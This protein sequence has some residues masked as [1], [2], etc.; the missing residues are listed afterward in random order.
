MEA[1]PTLVATLACSGVTASNT[2]GKS[3]LKAVGADGED[4][5]SA[6]LNEKSDEQSCE[7][8]SSLLS[9]A[10][11]STTRSS[12]RRKSALK[13]TT[14]SKSKLRS[15]N[16][17]KFDTNTGL[18]NGNDQLSNGADSGSS[19]SAEEVKDENRP[20]IPIRTSARRPATP[21]PVPVKKNNKKLEN[22]TA[23]LENQSE[24]DGDDSRPLNRKLN[25]KSPNKMVNGCAKNRKQ[26]VFCPNDENTLDGFGSTKTEL[27]NGHKQKQLN[28][29]S[30]NNSN[31]VESN[32]PVEFGLKNKRLK[33][34]PELESGKNS[35]SNSNSTVNMEVEVCKKGAPPSPEINVVDCNG[36]ESNG[37]NIEDDSQTGSV[38]GSGQS[39]TVKKKRRKRTSNYGI[40]NQIDG[41]VNSV[42][43]LFVYKWPQPNDEP[44]KTSVQEVDTYI[45]QE[46]ISEYLGVK[47]FKRKYPDLFRR[48]ID[49]K[50]RVYLKENNVVTETQCDLGLTA[51]RLNDCLDIMAD[52]YPEKYTELSEYLAKQR[53]KDA[54]A[55]IAAAAETVVVEQAEPVKTG[56]FG[57]A[58]LSEADRMKELMKKAIKSVTAFNLNLQKEKKAE[59]GSYFDLQTMRIQQRMK[60]PN[61]VNIPSIQVKNQYPVALLT[62]QYQYHYKKYSNDEMKHLPINTVLYPPETPLPLLYDEWKMKQ[63][64]PKKQYKS[65]K[66][67]DSGDETEEKMEV[68]PIE[69]KKMTVNAHLLSQH[70]H[71]QKIQHQNTSSIVNS[72][73]NFRISV[74]AA[75]T[76][77]SLIN[78]QKLA[79]SNPTKTTPVS[80]V[81][82]MKPCYVCS[83]SSQ[84][85][86]PN[87]NLNQ[88]DQFMVHCTSCD[89]YSHPTCL[90][91]NPSLVR[92]QSILEY[93][94]QCMDCKKCSGCLKPYDEDKMMFCDRCDRG[95]HTYCVGLKEVPSGSWFCKQCNTSETLPTNTN[96]NPNAISIAT[97]QT[98]SSS[99]VK[100]QLTTPARILDKIR[101]SNSTPKERSSTG[102]R[103]RPLGSLN[104]PKDPGSPNKKLSKY[105]LKQKQAMESSL[106]YSSYGDL[107]GM[108]DNSNTNPTSIDESYLHDDHSQSLSY[109]NY[110][111]IININMNENFIQSTF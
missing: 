76:V 64:N 10:S 109:D 96:A 40:I 90:E 31:E 80:T 13:V 32:M 72:P 38:S 47:S 97:N 2:Q 33:T 67:D 48:L 41:C 50:E 43:S 39:E 54:A 105:K 44:D 22:V 100:S 35:N 4:E 82:I 55:A 92:W 106:N 74:S 79:T 23:T 26:S 99:M 86:I 83:R 75:P 28:A 65:F 45:L 102:K 16:N 87:A 73:S 104:K 21:K 77:A 36:D 15:L 89:R 34:D 60:R 108:Q 42:E 29:I 49:I 56:R 57:R 94:W 91:L 61:P 24:Q 93:N 11:N 98:N 62:G 103:G 69:H 58:V 8:S 110:T 71:Q 63:L 18:V 5:P 111:N 66:K 95:F 14:A 3:T 52:S 46:Q 51:L 30:N 27:T 9:A 68:E 20:I 25:L 85:N 59:R 81:P 19:N 12:T 6:M 107:S 84:I 53:R 101:S 1:A 7:S 70:H 88:T 78:S 17:V 37:L